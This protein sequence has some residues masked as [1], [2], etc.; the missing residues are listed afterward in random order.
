MVIVQCTLRKHQ[1]VENDPP[2]PRSIPEALVTLLN[3]YL[4]RLQGRWVT[5]RHRLTPRLE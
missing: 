2:T 1:I 3:H 5:V 4:T